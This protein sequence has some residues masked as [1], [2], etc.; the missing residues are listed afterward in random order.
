MRLPEAVDGA[1][2]V[3]LL[4]AAWQGYRRGGIPALAGLAGFILGWWWAAAR[5]AEGV[6]WAAGAGV[7]ETLARFL[8]SHVAGWLSP[9]VAGAPARPHTLVR[10]LDDLGVLPLRPEVREELAEGLR[11]SLLRRDQGAVTVGEVLALV[12]ARLVLRAACVHAVPLL[13]GVL[14]AAAARRVAGWLP[15]RLPGPLDRPAGILAGAAEAAVVLAFSLVLAQTL[16]GLWPRQEV[17]AW[18]E[19]L[20]RSQVAGRLARWAGAWARVAAGP[21]AAEIP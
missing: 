18:L 8:E 14:A 13:A 9:E 21:A 7:L 1:V 20:D 3:V 12:V 6:A 5:A 17:T 19:A 4:T 15:A 2:T 10:A 11:R 16:G